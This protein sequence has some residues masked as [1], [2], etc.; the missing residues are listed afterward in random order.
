MSLWLLVCESDISI[1]CPSKMTHCQSVMV[2]QAV[3]FYANLLA[4]LPCVACV[5]GREMQLNE[6]CVLWLRM[7]T[8][9]SCL[10]KEV[11]ITFNT[12]CWLKILEPECNS[13]LLSTTHQFDNHGLQYFIWKLLLIV[14]CKTKCE[15][16]KSIIIISWVNIGNLRWYIVLNNNPHL[17]WMGKL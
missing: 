5:R 11:I 14:H 15:T 17:S 10:C 16:L 8:Q 2:L 9:L 13:I 1:Y 4:K 7:V 3:T 12:A 6:C